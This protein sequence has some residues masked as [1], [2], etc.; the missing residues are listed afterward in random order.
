MLKEFLCLAHC[1]NYRV[2]EHYF[3]NIFCRNFILSRS[4]GSF[5]LCTNANFQKRFLLP[6]NFAKIL[7]NLHL[8][9]TL[10][11]LIFSVPVYIQ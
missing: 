7:K 9:T 1:T 11:N 4:F 2:F 5:Q 8:T 10:Y 3:L 6:S